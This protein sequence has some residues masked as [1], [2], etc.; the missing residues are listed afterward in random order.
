M[1]IGVALS[2]PAD[3]ENA[4]DAVVDQAHA[5]KSAGIDSVWLG[6]RFDYDS[7]AL[8][9]I[10]GREVPGLNVGTSAVPIFGRHPLCEPAGKEKA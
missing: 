5:A 1:T 10:V 7:V 8:A 3:A 9:G 4:V 6:Q 2:V